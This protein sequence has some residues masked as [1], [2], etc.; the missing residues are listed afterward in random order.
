MKKKLSFL[1]KTQIIIIICFIYILTLSL[2]Y[3]FFKESLTIRGVASTV[4][5]YEGEKLPVNAVIRDSSNNYYFT[6]DF[7]EGYLLSYENEQ[8]EDDTYTLELDKTI[9]AALQRQEI[10]YTISFANP[11]VLN[12]TNGYVTT[13]TGNNSEDITSTS[14]T[15]SKTE[16]SPG[17][18]ADISFK[19]TA[20]NFNLTDSIAKATIT[21][22]YQN[23]PRYLYFV[24]KYNATPS[25]QNLLTDELILSPYKSGT[26]TKVESG[27][28]VSS[29][30]AVYYR[31]YQPLFNDLIGNLKPGVK[32]MLIRDYQGDMGASNGMINLRNASDV[33][34]RTPIGVGIKSVTFTLTQEQIDSIDRMYIYGHATGANT[35]KFI[36]LR[37]I[38]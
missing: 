10:T 16:I 32:Y 15:L 18:T 13:S 8:W 38:D 24:I 11:S 19:I 17:E 21:Y 36:Q 20:N 27:F 30:P 28:A 12:Y 29:Y 34:V 1:K 26:V 7:N 14:G 25:Y 6:A 31:S 37:Q 5:Y 9:L 2:G 22:T 4:E 33:I 23:K 3:A 35:F